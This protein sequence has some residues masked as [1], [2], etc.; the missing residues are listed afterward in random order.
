MTLHSA[1]CKSKT[2]N[3]KN[4][5][6]G[7]DGKKGHRHCLAAAGDFFFPWLPPPPPPM[8]VVRIVCVI[9]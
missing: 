8:D 1:L 6:T 5:D 7:M 9:A 3:K 2:G 4:D